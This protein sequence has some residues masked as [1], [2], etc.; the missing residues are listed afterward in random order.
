M[1]LLPSLSAAVLLAFSPT[2][3]ANTEKAIFLAPPTDTLSEIYDWSSIEHKTLTPSNPILRT[4]LPVAFPTTERP[5][6][7]DSW[8]ELAELEEGRRYEV[9][10][11]W[12]ATVRLTD[13][14]VEA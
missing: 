10:I 4:S 8:Y 1:K 5:H 3:L 2:S 6:G 13:L 14:N 12:A 9:R 11:C 7:L